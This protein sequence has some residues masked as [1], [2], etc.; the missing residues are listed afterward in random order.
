MSKLLRTTSA[1]LRGEHDAQAYHSVATRLGLH[2]LGACTEES[3]A[4]LCETQVGA[5]AWETVP[6]TLPPHENALCACVANVSDDPKERVRLFTKS[7]VLMEVE[8][9]ELRVATPAKLQ[10]GL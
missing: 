3:Y 4:E 9:M 1:E 10:K 2:A 7:L 8:M 6:F 5:K